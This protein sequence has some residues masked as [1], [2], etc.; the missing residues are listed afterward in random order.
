[1]QVIARGVLH[2]LWSSS[3]QTPQL[4]L[5]HRAIT[6][7]CSADGPSLGG[8]PGARHHNVRSSCLACKHE[9]APLVPTLLP[10]SARP[11]TSKLTASGKVLLAAMLL[12]HLGRHPLRLCS[13]GCCT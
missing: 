13:C 1:M 10:R 5:H 8:V 9:I 12:M 4:A 2:Q 7:S 6:S 3:A 11:A